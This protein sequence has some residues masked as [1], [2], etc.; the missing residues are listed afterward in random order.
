MSDVE[1]VF[2]RGREPVVRRL[3]D[4]LAEAGYDVGSREMGAEDRTSA[5]SDAAAILILWDRSTMAHPGLQAAAS[6]A[7]RRD[8]AIDVS[9]DG[10]TPLG[11]DD[12]R[13]LVQLS[14][15]R[16]DP[17]HPG[18][19]RILQRLDRLCRPRRE[20]MPARP[21][22]A[23]G[24]ASAGGAS[25]S[26]APRRMWAG[27]ATILLLIVVAAGVL[28]A[29]RGSAPAP[30]AAPQAP[31]AT[32]RL[33]SSAAPGEPAATG[34]GD[35]AGGA[36][37]AAPQAPQSAPPPATQAAPAPPPGAAVPERGAPAAHASRARTA[38]VVRGPRPGVR[39]TR[40]SRNMRLFCERAGR[41]TR[42]CR[43][44]N[45]QAGQ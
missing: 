1:I 14:G 33:S 43:V 44:F 42:E 24:R 39:Y 19:R 35:E 45:A 12:D 26:R 4:A 17:H 32:A 28:T 40:Y 21:A 6:A 34:S 27:A 11:L 13:N 25:L 9:V 18:W 15:W 29:R 16:G 38:R 36:P 5:A 20:A 10:I 30:G 37:Q 3:R 7:R 23:P 22:A 8:R 31:P 41:R 2:P